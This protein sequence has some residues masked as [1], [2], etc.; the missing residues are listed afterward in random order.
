M[1]R[2][3]ICNVTRTTNTLPE[4]RTESNVYSVMYLVKTGYKLYLQC[5]PN[6]IHKESMEAKPFLD[7]ISPEAP[8][9]PA[10]RRST[11]WQPSP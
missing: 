9:T 4:E 5:H 7:P 8:A 2:N 1:V 11:R 3:S 10:P 6:D